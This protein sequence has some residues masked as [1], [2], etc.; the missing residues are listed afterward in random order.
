MIK[1][2][3]QVNFQEWQIYL[4]MYQVLTLYQVVTKVN[5]WI[6]LKVNFLETYQ[7]NLHLLFLKLRKISMFQNMLIFEE[8]FILFIFIINYSY[9]IINNIL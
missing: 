4:I 7:A 9:K 6:W 1:Q 8:L 5:Y 3:R 2:D